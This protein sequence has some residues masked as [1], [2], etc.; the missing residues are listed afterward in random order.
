MI[1]DN[2]KKSGGIDHLHLVH[3]L[4]VVQEDLA[5]ITEGKGVHVVAAPGSSHEPSEEICRTLSTPVNVRFLL[6]H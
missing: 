3:I 2:E 4:V 6:A 1:P 5:P